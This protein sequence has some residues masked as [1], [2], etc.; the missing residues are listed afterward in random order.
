MHTING[1]RAG[2]GY[3]EPETFTQIDQMPEQ[4]PTERRNHRACSLTA[5]QLNE[6]LITEG[7]LEHPH[8]FGN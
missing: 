4:V 1:T 5:V 8:V 7:W 3:T 2:K 6:K